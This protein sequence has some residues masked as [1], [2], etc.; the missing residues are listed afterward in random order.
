M[1]THQLNDD[2]TISFF[3]GLNTIGGVH[4]VVGRGNTGIV[5]DL[6]LSVRNMF[7]D[8][9]KASSRA[10]ASSFLLTRSAPPVINLYREE[11]LNGVSADDLKRLWRKDELPAYSNLHA[12]VSHIHQDHMALLPYISGD[13]P[14]YMHKD[15]YAV[16][17]AVVA[18]GEYPD[19][20]APIHTLEDLQTVELGNGLK[21]Q[22]VEVDHDTPGVSGF[23][24]YTGEHT[25]AFT[26]DWRRH[27]LY[28]ERMDRF[29]ELARAAGA[30][31]L[32]TEGTTL[33]PDTL[34]RKEVRHKD[35][36]V[37]NQFQSTL[38][39]AKGLVYVNILSRNV[40]RVANIIISAQRAGRTLVMDESTAVFWH[41][42]ITEGIEALAGHPALLAQHDVIR[43][44]K[45][46][47]PNTPET[48]VALPFKTIELSDVIADKSAYAVF[49]TYKQLPLLAEFEA[50]GDQSHP[51]YYVHA[52]G[53]PLTDRDETLRLWLTHFSIKYVYCATG[54]HAASFEI[55]DLVEAVRP[56][57]VIPLHSNHPTLFDSRG[58]ARFY[59]T[60]GETAKL[61]NIIG[62]PVPV[63]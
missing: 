14:V 8:S 40:E 63:I 31:L 58:I 56:K 9:V 54:G 48:N 33:R 25:I 43:V 61:F 12:F 18:S 3:G 6:G 10:G 11:A 45:V 42:A 37:A 39:E 50:Q 27:G 28:P 24:L 49:L 60:L 21:L 16:H 4:I 44:M 35:I 46:A 30:D 53:N 15:A 38:E 17:R 57:V 2:T 62:A 59:P 19:T 51:S 34:F 47:E 26:A 29:A 52:D 55:S 20:Q 5:F 13:V 23:L 7:T 41:T 32:I 22:I 36:D 1:T